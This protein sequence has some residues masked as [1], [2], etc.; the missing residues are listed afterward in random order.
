MFK[1]K[2]DSALI[3]KNGVDLSRFAF[4]D[5]TDKDKFTRTKRLAGHN[6]S[7]SDAVSD[8]P[9]IYKLCHS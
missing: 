8:N 6:F 5:T 3:V 9:W 4:K 7:L 2:A 1:D